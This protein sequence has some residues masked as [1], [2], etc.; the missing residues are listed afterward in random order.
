MNC[1]N[2]KNI[3]EDGSLVYGELIESVKQFLQFAI[4]KQFAVEYA[5]NKKQC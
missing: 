3:V 2:S 4:L 1:L 5:V